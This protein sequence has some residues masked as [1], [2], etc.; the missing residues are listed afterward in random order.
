MTDQEKVQ[1]LQKYFHMHSFFIENELRTAES[2]FLKA[3]PRD[4]VVRLLEF[5][6]AKCFKEKFDQIFSDVSRILF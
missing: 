2:N 3:F 6:K 1:L 5:Y 4:D